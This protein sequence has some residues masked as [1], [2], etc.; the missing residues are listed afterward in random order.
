MSFHDKMKIIIAESVKIIAKS[1]VAVGLFVEV[2]TAL[3]LIDK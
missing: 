3:Q 1:A 2:I